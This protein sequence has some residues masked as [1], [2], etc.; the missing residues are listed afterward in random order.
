VPKGGIMVFSK[1]D[2]FKITPGT[3]EKEGTKK[4]GAN[5]RWREEKARC[6][7]LTRVKVLTGKTFLGGT[8]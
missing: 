7:M 1:R 8:H 4:G 6:C 3:F 5:I 2:W